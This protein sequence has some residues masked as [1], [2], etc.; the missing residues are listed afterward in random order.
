METQYRGWH[1]GRHHWRDGDDDKDNSDE[2]SCDRDYFRKGWSDNDKRHD[3]SFVDDSDSRSEE[4]YVPPPR[5][6]DDDN[7]RGGW[8]DSDWWRRW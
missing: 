6:N 8:R 4:S 1:S 7:H 3:Y 2:A 5:R